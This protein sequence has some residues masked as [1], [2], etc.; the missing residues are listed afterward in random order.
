MIKIKVN[1]M[2]R[3]IPENWDEVTFKMFLGLIEAK[4]DTS[5]V[6]PVLLDMQ[7]PGLVLHL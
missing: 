2:P 4:D 5:K 1:G 7:A 3:Q 6:I